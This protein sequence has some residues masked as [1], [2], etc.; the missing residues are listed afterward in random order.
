[1]ILLSCW[2]FLFIPFSEADYDFTE[3]PDAIENAADSVFM[4]EVYGSNRQKMAI[5]SGFLAFDE[6]LL[7]TNYHVIEDAAYIIAISD[8]KEQY[9]VTEVCAEDKTRDI[10]ILKISNTSGLKTLS[11]DTETQLKRSMKVVA[12]GSPAGL[13]NTISIGNI[14][15]FYTQGKKDWIQFT[16]PIS[17]GSSGGPLFNSDGKVI[18][19]TVATYTSAQNVNM[20]LRAIEVVNLYQKW[21][22]SHTA[23]YTG[24]AFTEEDLHTPGTEEGKEETETVYVYVT[25]SGRKYHNNPTC[26]GMT[27][28]IRIELFR[29]IE[30]GYEPCG[31]CYR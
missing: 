13:M 1:M 25:A 22:G 5:G 28:P 2:I 31:K 10:A 21:K 16:A 11:F 23:N 4:L 8:E 17:S 15:A 3:D 7:V 30:Q 19:V 29:A 26:S 14:S 24:L 9:R 27:R 6:K 18:G 12:I 20:A